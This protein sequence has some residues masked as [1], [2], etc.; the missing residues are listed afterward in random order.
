[1]TESVYTMS[2]LGHCGRALSAT[3]LGLPK[4]PDP[5]YLTR[6]A[7]EGQRH[8]QFIREDLANLGWTV[9]PEQYCQDCDRYGMHLEL[10][11]YGITLRGHADGIAIKEGESQSYLC[12]FKALGKNSFSAYKNHGLNSFKRYRY[13]ITA[14]QQFFG[15]PILYVVKSRDTGEMIV[16]VLETPPEEMEDVWNRIT[17][18][19]S[20]AG[21]GV[22]FPCDNKEGSREDL[23]TCIRQCREAVKT[24][25]ITKFPGISPEL[26]HATELWKTSNHVL[27]EAEA[28]KKEATEALRMVVDE[29]NKTTIINGVKVTLI[30]A[31]VTVKYNVPQDIKDEYKSEEPRAEYLRISEV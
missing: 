16:R 1:M 21:E 9:S 3:R 31:G 15:L 14:Y 18:I 5:E 26:L 24:E 20:C 29:N 13:Q 11:K 25:S 30:P 12:E 22:L 6:A 17:A 27:K 23:F 4:D 19:E 2:S 7:V 28:Q 10:V 8:E